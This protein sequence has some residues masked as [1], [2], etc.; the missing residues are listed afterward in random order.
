MQKSFSILF[1]YRFNFKVKFIKSRKFTTSIQELLLYVLYM[2][3]NYVG[4]YI[5]LY[6]KYIY[7]IFKYRY[8]QPNRIW[9]VWILIYMHISALKIQVVFIVCIKYNLLCC[10]E[11]DFT[12]Q[13]LQSIH[14]THF[15]IIYEFYFFFSSFVHI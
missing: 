11:F 3:G 10:T 7:T 14:Y 13:Y 9:S 2:S 12:S 15:T 5:Y 4:H 1:F 6:T 8:A